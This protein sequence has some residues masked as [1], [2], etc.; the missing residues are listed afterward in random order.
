MKIKKELKEIRGKYDESRQSCQLY[1]SRVQVLEEMMK[2]SNNLN[3]DTLNKA[4]MQAQI[5][6]LTKEKNFLKDRLDGETDARKLLEDHAKIVGEEVSKLR[7]E[8]NQGEKE[9]LEA[10]TRL[11][12][13]STY[14][15]EKETQLQKY[16]PIF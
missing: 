8:Y 6:A 14:F 5:I 11:E 15:K 1:E 3:D 7:Q 10:Q 12:V 4:D 13:L 9:K 16:R 2:K